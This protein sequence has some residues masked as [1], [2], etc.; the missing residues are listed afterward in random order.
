MELML[1][2]LAV[3]SCEVSEGSRTRSGLPPASATQVPPRS[4]LSTLSSSGS[5]GRTSPGATSGSPS[6]GSKAA[7]RFIRHSGMSRSMAASNS[8]TTSKACSSRRMLSHTGELQWSGLRR[9]VMGEK[10]PARGDAAHDLCEAM[11]DMASDPL[12]PGD[13]RSAASGS[14]GVPPTKRAANWLG[15]ISALA[16]GAALLAHRGT[17]TPS[18]GLRTQG[19]GSP[20]PRPAP[21]TQASSHARFTASAGS[22]VSSPSRGSSRL[23]RLAPGPSLLEALEALPKGG[24]SGPTAGSVSANMSAT[25]SLAATICGEWHGISPP[26]PAAGV[27]AHRAGV[28]A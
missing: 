26:P 23:Q 2:V 25:R 27:P 22:A 8:A 12:E 20:A 7:S 21:P 17:S 18:P 9:D 14:R 15:L 28:L 10:G 5:D 6:A 19:P 1:A 11:G 16:G 3:C 4:T 13:P 24:S